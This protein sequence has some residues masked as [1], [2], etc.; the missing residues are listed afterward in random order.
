L[1]GNQNKV[2]VAEEKISDGYYGKWGYSG[3]VQLFPGNV[4]DQGKAIVTYEPFVLQ[5][6]AS[7]IFLFVIAWCFIWCLFGFLEGWV[8]KKN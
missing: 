2:F 8:F 4:T 3:I 6:V 1:V 5:Y 7:C